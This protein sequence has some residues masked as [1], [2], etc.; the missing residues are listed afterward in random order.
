MAE[1]E[2]PELSLSYTGDGW[3]GLPMMQWLLSSLTFFSVA[4]CLDAILHVMISY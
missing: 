4:M 1:S 3:G 2:D